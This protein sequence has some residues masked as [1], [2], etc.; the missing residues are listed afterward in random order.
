MKCFRFFGV[1]RPPPDSQKL[2]IIERFFGVFPLQV[3]GVMCKKPGFY[4]A[5]PLDT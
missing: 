2:G 1:L 3:K 4:T 5:L